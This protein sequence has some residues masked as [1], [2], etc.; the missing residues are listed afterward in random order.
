M[1]PT[2]GFI[3]GEASYLPSSVAVYPATYPESTKNATTTTLT[4]VVSFKI[5]ISLVA[6]MMKCPMK[7]YE[8]RKNRMESSAGSLGFFT[9]LGASAR[10]GVEVEEGGSAADA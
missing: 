6:S 1:Y 2:S 9:F 8:M 4:C 10:P 5:H 7:M 3:L